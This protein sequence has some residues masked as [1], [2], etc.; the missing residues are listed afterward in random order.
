[1]DFEETAAPRWLL[2]DVAATRRGAQ[3][4]WRSWCAEA[5]KGQLVAVKGLRVAIVAGPIVGKFQHCFNALSRRETGDR[6]P[7][8]SPGTTTRDLGRK[9]A[10]CS[11][12]LPPHLDGTPAGISATDDPNRSSWG[13]RPPVIMAD[14]DGRCGAAYMVDSA[15]AGTTPT[16]DFARPQCR[17]GAPAGRLGQTRR[18][19]P[20]GDARPAG[21]HAER[22]PAIDVDD[23]APATGDGLKAL[24]DRPAP[25]CGNKPSVLA[26]VGWALNGRQRDLAPPPRRLD[27]SLEAAAQ[28]SCPTD[29]AIDLRQGRRKFGAITGEE[30]PK[31][32]R[33]VRRSARQMSGS[34]LALSRD[35]ADTVAAAQSLTRCLSL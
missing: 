35:G 3:G 6:P 9:R 4:V 33:S 26:S 1:V 17:I 19:W 18:I 24:A 7:G 28:A 30:S 32:A 34:G 29:S 31:R 16:R 20:G 14:G 8:T 23:Q 13:H 21:Q 27:R 2:A 15:R 11:K 12:G 22:R 25:G 5:A 10:R